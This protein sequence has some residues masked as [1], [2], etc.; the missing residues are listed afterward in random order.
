MLCDPLHN[1]IRKNCFTGWHKIE[2]VHAADTNAGSMAQL[3]LFMMTPTTAELRSAVE[4]LKALDHRLNEH[5]AHSVKQLPD[6]FLGDRHADVIKTRTLEQ[7]NRIGKVVTQLQNWR[8]E[9]LEQQKHGM[10]QS[11]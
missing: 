9:L 8:E 3:T 11:V 7:T 2:P 1:I 6:D 5:A 10:I 4:V